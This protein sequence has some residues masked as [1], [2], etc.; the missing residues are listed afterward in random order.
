MGRY[1]NFVNTQTPATL[2]V[3]ISCYSYE[4]QLYAMSWN[5]MHFGFRNQF[6]T[7]TWQ[8]LIYGKCF[9]GHLTHPTP[10]S[11]NHINL[12][13]IPLSYLTFSLDFLKVW[14]TPNTLHFSSNIVKLKHQSPDSCKL[15]HSTQALV[16]SMLSIGNLLMFS[17]ED[18]TF[19]SKVRNRS[20]ST[21]M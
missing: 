12:N 9:L 15:E 19:C 3:Q 8:N 11:L 18:E 10:E 20:Q 13:T 16:Q 14:Q 1:P 5:T 2:W 17:E 4:R 21:L 6:F 7:M